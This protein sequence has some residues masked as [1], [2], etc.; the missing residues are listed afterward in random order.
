MKW[1]QLVSIKYVP[2]VFIVIDKRALYYAPDSN[3]V[4]Y[5]DVQQLM[6]Y[7]WFVG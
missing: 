4:W 6:E 2:F 3:V 1:K 5:D 7:R